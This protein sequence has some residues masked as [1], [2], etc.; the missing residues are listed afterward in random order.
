MSIVKKKNKEVVDSLCGDNGVKLT[1][2]GDKVF[3]SFFAS[4]FSHKEKDIQLWGNEAE[5]V[6]EGINCR[7]DKGV[8]QQYLAT[9]KKIKS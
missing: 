6:G 4:V 8:V 7:T 1:G 5:N 9:L 3:S 2:D